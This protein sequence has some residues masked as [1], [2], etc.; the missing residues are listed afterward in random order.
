MNICKKD[1]GLPADSFY[2]IRAGCTDVQETKFR[3]KV[4]LSSFIVFLFH[5]GN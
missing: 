5:F 4:I 2:E 1:P 3:I